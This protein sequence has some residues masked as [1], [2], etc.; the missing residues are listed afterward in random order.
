MLLLSY[1][2][3]LFLVVTAYLALYVLATNVSWALRTPRPGRWGRTGESV[4]LWGN[5]LHLGGIIRLAY[6]LGVPYVILTWG[7]S[8]PL[9]LGLAD[10]DW[11]RGVGQSV[12]LTAG[13]LALLGLIWWQ[14]VRNVGEQPAMPQACSLGQPWGWVFVLRQ[15]IFLEAAWA[16]C[17][18]PMLLLA[19]PYLG[20]YLGL[21]AV[22]VAALLNARVRHAL[23]APG[24]R[25]EAVLTA[26]LAVATSTQYVFVHNLWL[27]I[28]MH[29]FL[30]MLIL[31]LVCWSARHRRP[32]HAGKE[33]S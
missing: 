32:E 30:R 5:R 6:Y 26:S 4:R 13:S 19:G 16:L 28:A 9:D 7:W 25:E 2:Q 22:A 24:E 1:P 12:G 29:F 27:C 3:R 31:Q 14:Y 8:S 20:V 15:A 33:A 10:L 18:S 17:R 21:G 11:V 23:G